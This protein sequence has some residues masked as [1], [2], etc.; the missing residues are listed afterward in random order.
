MSGQ[1]PVEEVFTKKEKNAQILTFPRIREKLMQ[2]RFGT[3]VQA[4]K[5][6]YAMTEA[7]TRPEQKF[8]ACF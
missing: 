6:K 8:R 1:C 4:T 2:A 7:L 5:H 3:N